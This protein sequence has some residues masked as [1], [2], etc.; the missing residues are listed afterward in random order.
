MSAELVVVV[1]SYNRVALLRSALEHLHA[2]LTDLGRE[3]VLV[4]FDAGSTDGSVEHLRAWAEAHPQ[5]PTLIHEA[6]E[7]EPRSFAAGVNRACALV[8]ERYPGAPWLL[9]YETDNAF[10]SAQPL[11]D[12]IDLAEAHP[13]LGAVGF[14]ARLWDGTHVGWGERMPRRRDFVLGPRATAFLT[15]RGPLAGPWRQ[16]H[17][18]RWRYADVAY[19]SPLLVR[20]HT[21]WQSGGMDAATFPFSDSDVDWCWRIHQHGWRIA[22]VRTDDVI[23]DNLEARSE[24]AERRVLHFHRAR[25]RLFAKHRPGRLGWLRPAVLARQAVEYALLALASPFSPEAARKRAVREALLADT[26]RPNGSP[27]E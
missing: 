15:R 26:L 3:A 2:A 4:V 23:N 10:V 27:D 13:E 20:A 24:W 16:E 22:V 9:F 17:G 11:H 19:T 12:A 21:W 1:N 25:F 14:T 18:V 5:V 6:S 8:R 7:D